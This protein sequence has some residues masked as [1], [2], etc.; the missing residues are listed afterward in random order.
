MQSWAPGRRPALYV[1]DGSRSRHAVVRARQTHEGGRIV[2]RLRAEFIS[3]LE[4][5]AAARPVR[6]ILSPRARSGARPR[7]TAA[8]A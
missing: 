7:I 5:V 2:Y 4:R 8:E 1:W 6:R 3:A